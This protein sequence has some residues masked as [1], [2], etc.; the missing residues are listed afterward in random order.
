[1][2]TFQSKGSEIVRN[3]H[4]VDAKDEVLGRMAT[5][6]AIYLTGKHKTTYSTQTDSGDFVVV[7]NAE[8]VKLTGKKTEKKVYRGHSGYPKG[9][10]EISFAKMSK[11]HPERVIEHAVSGMVPD[12][13]L[14]S[15]RMARLKVVAGDKNPFEAKFK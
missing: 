2:K 14:K 7:L 3:W 9:F 12:N 1:M 10:K 5:K 11:E 15:Q 13:R 8:R 4:L 6:V